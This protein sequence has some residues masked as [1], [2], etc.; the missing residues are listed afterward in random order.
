MAAT[1]TPVSKG[2]T[3]RIATSG[4]AGAATFQVSSDAGTTYNGTQ[5]TGSGVVLNG[6]TGVTATFTG[7]FVAGDLYR[8]YVGYGLLRL[9]LDKGPNS[10]VTATDTTNFCRDCHSSWAMDHVAVQTYTG[11]ARSHPVGVSLN[12]NGK[13]YDRAAPLSAA[14]GAQGSN[15]ATDLKLASDGTIQCF[16]CHGA[17]NAPSNSAQTAYTGW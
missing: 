3:F 8:S 12:A 14:G 6:S 17:H 7:S 10:T 9:P 1:G 5:A 15:A 4:A 11:T 2:Y 16:T 13:G